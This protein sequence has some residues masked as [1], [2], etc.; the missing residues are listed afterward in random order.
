MS[1]DP[2][3]DSRIDRS[4]NLAHMANAGGWWTVAQKYKV[5]REKDVSCAITKTAAAS[6]PVNIAELTSPYEEEIGHRQAGSMFRPTI[7]PRLDKRGPRSKLSLLHDS[8]GS[9]PRSQDAPSMLKSR[10]T[11]RSKDGGR[12]QLRLV[13]RKN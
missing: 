6:I 10:P 7:S 5:G 8:N 12:C 1:R 11:T 13:S 9:L 4:M 2:A 3:E